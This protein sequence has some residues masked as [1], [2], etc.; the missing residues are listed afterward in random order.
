[1]WAEN[2][3]FSF[4]SFL[5]A[6]LLRE[7]IPEGYVLKIHRDIPGPNFQSFLIAS[8]CSCDRTTWWIDKSLLGSFSLFLLLQ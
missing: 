7:G 3:R 8:P 6:S 4:Q 2:I 5:I 1:M